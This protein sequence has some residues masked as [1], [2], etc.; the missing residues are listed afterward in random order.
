MILEENGFYWLVKFQMKWKRRGLYD[1]RVDTDL[2]GVSPG[3]LGDE[4]TTVYRPTT[5][6][7]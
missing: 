2:A 3:D 6:N 1:P 5:G 4:R 7:T